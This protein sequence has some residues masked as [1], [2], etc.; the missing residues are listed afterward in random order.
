MNLLLHFV[1]TMLSL[2]SFA[3]VT[4]KFLK[5]RKKKYSTH[6]II[7]MISLQT[8]F[9]FVVGLYNL[10]LYASQYR[11]ISPMFFYAMSGQALQL[12]PNFAVLMTTVVIVYF[13]M[14]K[15]IEEFTNHEDSLNQLQS[16]NHELVKRA[17]E[18]ET[19]HN[20]LQ[21]KVVELEKFNEIAK[22]REEKMIALAKKIEVL[23]KRR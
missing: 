6:S 4:T 11:Y 15:K 13:I 17:N 14:E 22:S 3:L 18:L 23:E 1:F 21:R 12:I 7:R 2:I 16:L 19:S 8:L 10:I 9:L 20:Q 5:Y